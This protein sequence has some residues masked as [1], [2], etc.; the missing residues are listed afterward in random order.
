MTGGWEPPP[1]TNPSHANR[2]PFTR[3]CECC[4]RAFR[5]WRN[6]VG[7]FCTPQCAGM[8]RRIA[9]MQRRRTGPIGAAS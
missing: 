7:K 6:S 2:E 9:S 3:P 4:G 8:A 5:P 1:V